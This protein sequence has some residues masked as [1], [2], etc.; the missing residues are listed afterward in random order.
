MRADRGDAAFLVEDDDLV[1]AV[2]S[3]WAMT[4]RSRRAAQGGHGVEGDAR[5]VSGGRGRSASSKR[6]MGGF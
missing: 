6:T 5:F 1:G 2:S 3:L 4:M